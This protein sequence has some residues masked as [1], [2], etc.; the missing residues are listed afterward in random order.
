MQYCIRYHMFCLFI[1]LHSFVQCVKLYK[2]MWLLK[3]I[4]LTFMMFYM[5]LNNITQLYIYNY[6]FKI[7]HL[8]LL[9]IYIYI[10][11]CTTLV[12]TNVGQF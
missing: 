12:Q 11:K 5:G 4:T 10:Y 6:T 8:H 9:D 3:R 2:C 1:C 7:I